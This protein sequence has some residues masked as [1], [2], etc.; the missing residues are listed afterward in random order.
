MRG[1]SHIE[2][3][4]D[5]SYGFQVMVRRLASYFAESSASLLQHQLAVPIEEKERY[6]GYGKLHGCPPNPSDYP[7][8]LTHPRLQPIFQ[9]FFA[10]LGIVPYLG[11]RLVQ[12]W[13]KDRNARDCFRQDKRLI[14]EFRRYVA[15]SFRKFALKPDHVLGGVRIP[16]S[17]SRASACGAQDLT[18]HLESRAAELRAKKQRDGGTLSDEDEIRLIL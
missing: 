9:L 4:I 17:E 11:H 10:Q 13:T 8:K 12:N 15:V 3:P 1:E 14:G 18:D 5:I 6:G 2:L 7:G 16:L